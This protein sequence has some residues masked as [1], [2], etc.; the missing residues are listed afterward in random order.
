MLDF[1]QEQIKIRGSFFSGKSLFCLLVAKYMNGEFLRVHGI[2]GIL[3]GGFVSL[4]RYHP[5]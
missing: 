4:G 3:F 5:G 1:R 2:P